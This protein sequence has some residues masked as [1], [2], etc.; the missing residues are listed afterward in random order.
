MFLLAMVLFFII[1]RNQSPDFPSCLFGQSQFFFGKLCAPCSLL[2]LE[3]VSFEVSP[4]NLTSVLH[5]ETMFY[6]RSSSTQNVDRQ[7]VNTH[8]MVVFPP[9]FFL[10]YS[11]SPFPILSNDEKIISLHNIT[12]FWKEI[13]CFH[14]SMNIFLT[15]K[16]ACQRLHIIMWSIWMEIESTPI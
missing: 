6:Q 13:D 5:R 12:L 2:T 15:H 9:L 8:K 16:V 4:Q 14:Q 3:K 7:R 10:K 1:L 11:H